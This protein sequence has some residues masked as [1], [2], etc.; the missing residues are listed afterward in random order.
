MDLGEGVG[1]SASSNIALSFH[2]QLQIPGVFFKEKK[3]DRS[4]PSKF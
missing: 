1:G 3:K 2:F 4:K